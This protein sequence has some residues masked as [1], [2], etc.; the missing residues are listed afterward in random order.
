MVRVATDEQV[1]EPIQ[2][3]S[4]G[5]ECQHRKRVV[6]RVLVV[7][8]RQGLQGFHHGREAE[9]RQEDAHHQHRQDVDSGPAECVL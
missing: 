4:H 8:V 9:R 5:A 6:H 2:Y 7:D 3:D 1:A